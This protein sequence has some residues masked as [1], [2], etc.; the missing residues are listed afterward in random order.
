[1]KESDAARWSTAS[2]LAQRES[3]AVQLDSFEWEHVARCPNGL[4]EITVQGR[5]T[6]RRFVFL[7]DAS[8]ASSMRMIAFSSRQAQS[9]TEVEIEHDLSSVAAELPW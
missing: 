7:M 3:V 1:V 5:K 2:A 9:C 6:N 8:H 4:W